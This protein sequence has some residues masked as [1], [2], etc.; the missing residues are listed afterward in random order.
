MSNK[1]RLIVFSL[2]LLLNIA[3]ISAQEQQCIFDELYGAQEKV[4]ST[5]PP[6]YQDVA[7]LEGKDLFL[8][9]HKLT[10]RNYKAHGYKEAK[11]Y[12]YDHIDNRNGK[13][14]TV[15][16]GL[17]VRKINARYAEL[18]DENGDGTKGDFVNCEHLWPQSKFEEKLPMVSDLHHLLP[19]FSKPNSMR[20]NYAF[21]V[22]K[23]DEV[24]Y[25]TSYGSEFDGRVFEPA[26]S[27]KGNVARAMMYF[28]LRYHNRKVFQK[29]D[30]AN[31]F[32]FNRIG[33]FMEWNKIDPPDDWEK[34]RND[35][36]EKYQG[37]RNP[38]IDHP[39]FVNLIGVD[40]FDTRQ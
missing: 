13:V 33:Q 10:G 12:M 7:G 9:L 20:S 14:F 8:A 19:A 17:F 16:S 37:N 22:V 2:L 23:A 18:D 26:D 30:S 34:S 32:W 11:S 21:G 4:H 3:L 24:E 5:V 31:N 38:F 29:T 25:K 36:I 6:R 35:I 39:E 40:G 15:Y 28:Y 27:V 1:I